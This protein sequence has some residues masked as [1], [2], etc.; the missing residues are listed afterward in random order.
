M[1]SSRNSQRAAGDIPGVV[2]GARITAALA[3]AAWFIGAPLVSLAGVPFPS[4]AQYVLIGVI[5]VLLGLSLAPVTLV[6]GRA[7][8]GRTKNFVRL[9]GL[10]ICTA[11]IPSGVLLVLAAAG[12]LGERAP[13]WSTAPA[14]VCIAALFLWVGLASFSFRGP[15]KIERGLFWVGLL[16]GALALATL[17]ASI[18]MFYFVRDFVYTN[19]TVL[20]LFLVDL[21]LWLSLPVWLIAVVIRL[22]ERTGG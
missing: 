21:L 7:M 11:L 18:L 17:V 9:S 10:A 3:A 16:T 6:I 13:D 15:S 1:K 20:P 12:R 2:L 22:S 5:A 19:A 14:I 8:R 4:D